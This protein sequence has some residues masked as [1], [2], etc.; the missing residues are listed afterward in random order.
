M[1]PH[2]KVEEAINRLLGEAVCIVTAIPDED[3]G[4]RLI[5]LHTHKEIT[6]ED[7]WQRLCQTDIPRL[8]IPRRDDIYHIE[9]I[10]ILGTGKIDM[11]Q[12]R[13]IAREMTVG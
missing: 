5:V 2:I 1:V 12:V 6:S 7:I 3:K 4:E 11:K 10:P 9:A 13:I 8:W